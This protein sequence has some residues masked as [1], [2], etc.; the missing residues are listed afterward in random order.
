MLKRALHL[1][2]V[3]C[4]ALNGLGA[5]SAVAAHSHPSTVAVSDAERA[6]ASPCGM[7][8]ATTEVATS[9]HVGDAADSGVPTAATSADCCGSDDCR[10]GCMLPPV[11][12]LPMPATTNTAVADA[13]FRIAAIE[14]SRHRH[15]PP[16]RPP[17]R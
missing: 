2:L 11:M 9:G 16:L 10:C 5:P 3:L 6:D 8:A 12:P 14:P 7:H 17:A 15:A 4:L 1:I 13:Q